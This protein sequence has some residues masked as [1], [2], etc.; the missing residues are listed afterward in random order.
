MRANFERRSFTMTDCSLIDFGFTYPLSEVE[1]MV[2]QKTV[3]MTKIEAG[4]HIGIVVG[5]EVK[6]YDS[7]KVKGEKYQYMVIFIEEEELHVQMQVGYPFYMATES[8][9][10]K[11]LER[12]GAVVEIDK[13]IEVKG[14]TITYDGKKVITR[15]KKVSFVTRDDTGN[16]GMTYQK[17]QRD[18]LNPIG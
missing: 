14:D 2:K 15:G 5:I 13:E 16:D 7:K 6:D 9:L 12:F 4:K 8:S 10:G 3:K 11:L 18:S 17:V 1:R